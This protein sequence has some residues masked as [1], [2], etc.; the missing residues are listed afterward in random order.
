M[1]YLTFMILCRDSVLFAQLRAQAFKITA[2]QIELWTLKARID[3]AR[4]II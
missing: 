1:T 3:L 2:P 4:S